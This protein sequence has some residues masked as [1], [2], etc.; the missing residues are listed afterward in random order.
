MS[1]ECPNIANHTKHP[2]GYVA[3]S[4]WA[5]K[6]MRRHFQVACPG[7]GLY[8][9]W[10]KQFKRMLGYPCRAL[11]IESTW[12]KIEAGEWRFI[13]GKG[14]RKITPQSIRGSL[15]G[16][17]EMGIPVIMCGDHKECGRVVARL[18]FISAR[19]RWR[20]LQPFG[21]LVL[22]EKER[23]SENQTTR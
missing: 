6:K 7:C 20:E 13:K 18:L 4:E 17:I 3:H 21:L 15:L 16:V 10:D 2:D 1:E 23:L 8:A 14:R 12:P 19:R 9:I 11:V 5:K 22:E